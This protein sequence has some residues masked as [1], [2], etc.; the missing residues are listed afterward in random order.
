M[1]ERPHADD[2]EAVSESGLNAGHLGG[3][4]AG[5]I[6]ADRPKGLS[7]CERK[8][9]F[10]NPAVDV[11][12][13]DS[14]NP[15]SAG[16]SGRVKDIDGALDIDSIRLYRCI[17]R[18]THVGL[19]GQVVNDVGGSFSEGVDQL[20]AVGDVNGGLGDVVAQ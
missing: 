7:F 8:I 3:R 9:A 13:S 15:G 17:P 11:S 16:E 2:L 20:G 4:L 18:P 12:A 14:E 6:R 5:G 19:S 10:V 1:V